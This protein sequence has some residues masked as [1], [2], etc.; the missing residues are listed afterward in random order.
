M[1]KAKIPA[2][3]ITIILIALISFSCSSSRYQQGFSYKPSY[4]APDISSGEQQEEKESA[5]VVSTVETKTVNS[6][7]SNH[8][9][10]TIAEP[11]NSSQSQ[12][13]ILVGIVEKEYSANT[14]SEQPINT[15]EKLHKMAAAYAESHI[16]R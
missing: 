9:S 10:E 12:Q 5:T 15:R 1:V 13:E 2:G 6:S 16:K 11:I 8:N 7:I 3:F 14:A 4:A